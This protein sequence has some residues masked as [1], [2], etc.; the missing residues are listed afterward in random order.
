M[1]TGSK[2]PTPNGSIGHAMTKGPPGI[3]QQVAEF[4]LR[5]RNYIN[6][7]SR[8]NDEVL[9]VQRQKFFFFFTWSRISCQHQ[10]FVVYCSPD[11]LVADYRV[12]PGVADLRG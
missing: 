11:Q 5:G 6:V 12:S 8:E 7:V 10:K 2:Q 1:Q 3:F 4:I 9:Q